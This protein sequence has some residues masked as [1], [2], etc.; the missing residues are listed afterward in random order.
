[1]IQNVVLGCRYVSCFL[2]WSPFFCRIQGWC[3]K[4]IST[5]FH[6]PAFRRPN[7][8]LMYDS[9]LMYDNILLL[10]KGKSVQMSEEL[11]PEKCCAGMIC[12]WKG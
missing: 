3:G 7:S 10:T 4:D 2:C 1:M 8:N 9:I 12:N 6:S 5:I 11:S